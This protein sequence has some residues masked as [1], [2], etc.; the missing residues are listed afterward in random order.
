LKNKMK[1]EIIRCLQDNYSYL[2]IDEKT[3]NACAIDPSE[4]KPLVNFIENNKI[5]LKYI[6]NTHHHYDHVGGNLELK[7]KYNSIVI[8]FKGDKERIPEIDVLV[9]DNQ[10]WKKEN[11]EAKIYHIPGHTSGHIAFH[12]YKEKKIFTGDTLFSL[13]CGKVFEGTYEQM[14]NSLNRIKKLP[15]DTEIYCGHEYTLK[16]SNFCLANDSE[17]SK[18]K[19]KILIV[20]EKLKKNI[21]TIPTILGDEVECNIFLKAKDL[22]SFSKLRELK[23]NF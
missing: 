2:L 6:L 16:N 23:D 20:K 3:K 9:E 13:G 15:I 10:L 4:A 22:K 14:F 21:P 17:N 12:F 7:K 8:G 11:F 1:I 5:N 18:L 19:E